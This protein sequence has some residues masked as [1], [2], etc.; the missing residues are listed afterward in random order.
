MRNSAT[1]LLELCSAQREPYLKDRQ[2][3]KD[4]DSSLDQIYIVGLQ[5][6]TPLY[7]APLMIPRLVPFMV[8]VF[9]S[10]VVFTPSTTRA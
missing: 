1:E 4:A 2:I 9:S 6:I 7:D 5:G 10:L 3:T 8:I